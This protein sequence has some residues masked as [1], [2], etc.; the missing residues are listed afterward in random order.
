M[1]YDDQIARISKLENG[2]TVCIVDE[3]QRDKNNDPKHKGPWQDPWKEYAFSTAEEVLNF[4]KDRLD[5]LEPPPDADAEYST[6]FAK[7]A[8]SDD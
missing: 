1:S 5:K 6:A 2:Y 7:D 3:E 4:L 8:A